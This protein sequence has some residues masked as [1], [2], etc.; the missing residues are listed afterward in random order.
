[1][2]HLLAG[3]RDVDVDGDGSVTYRE[4]LRGLR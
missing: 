2:R 3:L 1:M 4:L